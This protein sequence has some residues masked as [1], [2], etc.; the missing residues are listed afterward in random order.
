MN[1]I[2]DYT[3]LTF[4]ELIEKISIS[5]FFHLPKMVA[6]AL[7]KI[8]SGGGSEP[9][10]K[11]YAAL[12]TQLGTDAPVATV[13]ENTIGEIT[14]TYEDVGYYGVISDNL[15]TLNKTTFDISSKI[16]FTEVG[17]DLTYSFV[18][19]ESFLSINTYTFE[20]PD[21]VKS[22]FMLDKNFIEIRVYN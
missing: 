7:R 20:T 4:N 8:P 22:N 5:R 18:D 9:A 3:N 1:K 12:L 6:E 14:F 19:D 2:F 11:V 16:S 21:F 10:Y 15:F 13:L 17:G